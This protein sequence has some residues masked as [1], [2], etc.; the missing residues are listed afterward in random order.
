[1][2]LLAKLKELF[3]PVEGLFEEPPNHGGNQWEPPSEALQ[4]QDVSFNNTP[5]ASYERQLGRL[6][7]LYNVR[8]PSAEVRAEID[9]YRT[10]IN[11][12]GYESPKNA[13]ETE[14]HL[15]LL[16]G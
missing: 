1:M 3:T 12:L 7:N 11:G 15:A 14:T 2:G 13:D 5:T 8:N 9:H 6:L 16:R 4:A 10:S